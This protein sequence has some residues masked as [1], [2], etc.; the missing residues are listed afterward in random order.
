MKNLETARREEWYVCRDCGYAI[1]N[2]EICQATVI[3][4][5]YFHNK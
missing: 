3:P 1:E 2:P 5:N 4:D